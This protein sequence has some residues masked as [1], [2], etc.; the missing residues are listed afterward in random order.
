M[1]LN[2]ED[3][4]FLSSGKPHSSESF[5]LS[6]IHKKLEIKIRVLMNASIFVCVMVHDTVKLTA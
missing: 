5:V 1:V 3:L 4:T 6:T 2:F